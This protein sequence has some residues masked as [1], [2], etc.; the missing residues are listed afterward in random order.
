MGTFLWG[1]FSGGA[2]ELTK[3][4]LNR[5]AQPKPPGDKGDNLTNSTIKFSSILQN[6]IVRVSASAVRPKIQR[7]QHGRTML[8]TTW[9]S[10]T[11]VSL[12]VQTWLG[13][14]HRPG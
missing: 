5:L 6:F 13:S 3:G 14:T 10:G 1:T 9:S 2:K 8:L 12:G 7:S 4:P 11:T